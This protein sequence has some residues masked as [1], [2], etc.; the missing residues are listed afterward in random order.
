M[1]TVLIIILILLLIGAVPRWGYSSNWGYGPSGVLGL[2]LVVVAH[3]AVAGAF[4]KICI[5]SGHAKNCRGASGI[6]DEVDEAR[7]VVNAVADLLKNAG[8]TV[9]VFHDDV[10]DDQSENLNRIVDFHNSKTRDLD[11]CV[12]FNAYQDTNDPMGTECLFVTQEELAREVATAI[13][14]ASGLKNRGPK[15]RDDL[16]F[17]N[18]T[19]EPAILIEVCFVDSLT[20]TEL[21][22]ELFP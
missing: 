1:Y 10:S 21:Y 18:N 22:E 20:D 13:A 16:F 19:D 5:S 14:A 3:S 17:L 15:E 11:I 9:Y 12:H 8:V 2:I 7:K 4:M 6:I